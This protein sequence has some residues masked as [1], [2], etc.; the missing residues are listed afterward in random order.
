MADVQA[1]DAKAAGMTAAEEWVSFVA[2]A[3]R[4]QGLAVKTWQTR[5][6]WWVKYDLGTFVQRAWSDKRTG[7]RGFSRGR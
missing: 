7:R 3:M 6:R 5:T 4:K 1:H 2:G